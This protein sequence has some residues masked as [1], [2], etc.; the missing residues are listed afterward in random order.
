M[1]KIF[2]KRLLAIL[3]ICL[4]I[5]TV[6]CRREQ[7][8][9]DPDVHDPPPGEPPPHEPPPP[10][11]NQ[12]GNPPPQQPQ[13]PQQPAPQQPGNQPQQK[14]Q[15]DC[16]SNWRVDMA[17]TDIYADNQPHGQVFVRITNHGPCTLS[18][19]K[20]DF[21]C[22]IGIEN[23]TNKTFSND[24]ITVWTE[25]NMKPGETQTFPTGYNIDTST[26]RYNFVCIF[27]A[28]GIN[29][30]NPNNNQLNKDIK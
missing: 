3:L 29:E 26:F 23:H 15:G 4:L 28:G 5:V 11:P 16:G 1:K 13:Q 17:L 18:K 19:V 14:F 12:P 22:F 8:P 25:L 21:D 9:Y 30:L 6:S 24:Q 10:D 27:S 7:H 20:S 2:E